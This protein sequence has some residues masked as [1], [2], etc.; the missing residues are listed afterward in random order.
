MKSTQRRKMRAVAALSFLILSMFLSLTGVFASAGTARLLAI[1]AT[2]CSIL[3][4]LFG[5]SVIARMFGMLKTLEEFSKGTQHSND[6]N[7]DL[8][9]LVGASSTHGKYDVLSDLDSLLAFVNDDIAALKRS[10]KKFDL[11]SSDILFSARNLADQAERQL[12]M[13]LQLRTRA[14]SYF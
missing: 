2:I 7:I 11:F 12:T 10:A 5:V 14:Q 4:V 8:A 6:S 3:A 9:R 1:A 13:L